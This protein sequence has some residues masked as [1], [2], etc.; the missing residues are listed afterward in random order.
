MTPLRIPSKRPASGLLRSDWQQYATAN[1]KKELYPPA[2]FIALGPAL[3]NSADLLSL[4][5]IINAFGAGLYLR[6]YCL[7]F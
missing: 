1:D 7:E 6:S 5:F 4:M 2:Q 3:V